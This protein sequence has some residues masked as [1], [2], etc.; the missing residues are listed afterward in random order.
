MEK[1]K[2]SNRFFT[3]LK[4]VIGL[5]LL[6][7]SLPAVAQ[8]VDINGTVTDEFGD[9]LIGVSV[10]VKSEDRGTI[11]DIDGN[12][13]LK[14]IKTGAEIEFSYIGMTSKIVKVKGNQTRIDVVLAED[15]ELLD[16]VVV[17]ALGMKR[18][19]KALGYAVTEVKGDELR[20]ANSIS[21]VSALQGK[22]AGVEIAG[23][24]GG[25]FGATK[26]QI[27]GAST[28]SGN[29]QPIY[30]V[31][32][33]ILDNNTSG[34]TDLNWTANAGDFGNEL[35]NLNPDDFETVSVLKGAAATALYGSRG[36]NGAVVI[37]TKSGK[38]VQGI[39]V[40]VSQTIGFDTNVK[41]PD[42]QYEYGYGLFTGFRT[43]YGNRWEPGNLQKNSDGVE[44]FRNAANGAFAF[45]PRFDG[46]EMEN[47]DGTMTTYSPYKNG[48][49]HFFQTGFNSNT[50]VSVRGG[51]DK[52]TFFS[53]L[54]YKTAESTTPNNTFDRYSMLL[55]ASHKIT[56]KVTVEGSVNF[57]H[58]KPKNPAREIGL[59]SV[60]S[61]VYNT[62]RPRDWRDKYKGTHGGIA[63]SNYGDEYGYVPGT[64]KS[65][66]WNR[67]HANQVHKEYVVRPTFDV[68]YQI[69]DWLSFKAEINMNL[70][71]DNYESKSLGSGY[72]NEGGGYAISS[73]SKEQITTAGTITADKK[74]SDF[75]LGGFIRGEFFGTREQYNS[76]STNGG[77]VVP[78]EYFIENSKET[79]SFAG[80]VKGT[81]RMASVV[82]AFNGSWKDQVFLD[83]TGRN[84]WSSAL[85][86]SNG[87][88]NNSYFYPSVSGSWLASNTFELPEW[89]SFAK[90]RASWA[91]VGNDTDP[92]TIN[93][94]YSFNYIPTAAG[95]IYTNQFSSDRIYDQNLKPE[96][97]NA[98][99]VG[100]DLRF[101][102][103]RIG[104][105]ATYY[106]ENTKNQIMG[107]DVPSVSGV[108]SKVINAGDIQNS[109]IELA[110]KTIPVRT[111]D[112]E[113]GVDMTFTKNKS[114]I[115]KLHPD[116]ADYV[117]IEGQVNAYDFRIGSVAKVGGEYGM[118]MSDAMPKKNDKGEYVL[119]WNQNYRAAYNDRSGVVEE[120]GSMNPSFLSSL[121]SN[122]TW[123]NL[124]LRV[125]LDA[126]VGGYV[127]SYANRYGSY[128][129][130]TKS[131]LKYRDLNHGGIGFTSKWMDPAEFDDKGNMVK[132]IR[133]SESHGIEYTDGVIPNGVFAE[134]QIIQ[135]LD[136]KS[137]EVGGRSYA[138]LVDA[139]I[140]EPMHAGA[141]HFF[142]ND[143]GTGV[144]NDDWVQ[145]LNYIALRE[146]TLAYRFDKHIA[147]KIGAQGLSVAF[148][149][150]NLGYLYNSLRNNVNPE[151]VRGNRAGEF[152]IRSFNPYTASFM[153]TVN[154]DF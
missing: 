66:W 68:N 151:S 48:I 117:A 105:D 62:M 97:K 49:K 116:V 110:L 16:E 8:G 138:E 133:P 82:F 5:L 53:S 119:K 121:Q 98:W 153:F 4:N 43:A 127:A 125:A 31:D 152:R 128:M 15:T 148:T 30:V 12:W 88:G 141:Y 84:D 9:G 99:E 78:G 34:N 38:G 102:D 80:H 54:S 10:F 130:N 71:T 39:G 36:L 56:D 118:L 37:T 17:T 104:L 89:F 115:V 77:L 135:G 123:K 145:K 91:Q 129:G 41:Y 32:G 20:S 122:L 44:T 61:G 114:K 146:V 101:L 85:V 11:T 112:W 83:V 59:Y 57:A 81:K 120:V 96:R 65:L 46:R 1:C 72:K 131:S 63:N 23:S 70:Y 7:I 35:K 111:K 2:K 113:W 6:M 13:S 109:G 154:V 64:V 45:G 124:S 90:L 58:S 19:Q 22:V 75:T 126:R 25:M 55:K 3:R 106:R 26:I 79:P 93:Q 108:S 137:H 86:Y 52:T 67:D 100:L 139:G 47:Y 73:Y 140:L 18:D 76:A 40:S 28:L 21:P 50:N 149:G 134:G 33:V 95:N 132:P 74:V 107:I 150:R 136:G 87:T 60:Y 14:G 92:Y 147:N 29:N 142:R 51:N 103:Y 24:D 42:V 143:W 94:G 69:L 27:R 144:V